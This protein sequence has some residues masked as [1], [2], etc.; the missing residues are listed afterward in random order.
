VHHV[1]RSPSPGFGDQDMNTPQ[2]KTGISAPPSARQQS[3]P[4]S[5]NAVTTEVDVA[6]IDG[7]AY[8]IN[9]NET[10]LANS[11]EYR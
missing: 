7:K 2:A 5:S 6:Y 3:A 8:P 10:M 9:K 1:I 11:P 4:S